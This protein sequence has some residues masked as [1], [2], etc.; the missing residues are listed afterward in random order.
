ML[1]VILFDLDDT[2]YARGTGLWPAIGRRINEYMT[3]RLGL[4]EAEASRLRQRYLETYGTTLNGLRAEF[5]IDTEV[6][7]A[8]VHDL[9]LERYLEPSPELSQMLGRLPQRKIIFTNADTQHAERVMARLGV[10][11]HFERIIDVR[12]LNFVNKPQPAA[13]AQALELIGARAGECVFLDDAVR[14]LRPARDIG[15]TAVLVS[16]AGSPLPAGV[17]YQIDSILD[18]EA[19]LA[20]IMP[21]DV[22]APLAERRAEP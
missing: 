5:K 2:L 11:E 10:T 22:S 19:L 17:D 4:D 16:P 14:N 13:Y 20:R 21:A 6:Y 15:M 7:L 3:N 1:R 18:L 12:A 9:P 8:F